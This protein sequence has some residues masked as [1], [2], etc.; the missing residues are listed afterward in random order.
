MRKTICLGLA[1]LIG[2]AYL[3]VTPIA[4]A[5]TGA[6]VV[7]G[8][9]TV[10]STWKLKVSPDKDALNRPLIATAFEV[11]Q[12]IVGQRWS[13]VIRRDTTT[14][15]SSNNVITQAPSG[16]F[17]VVSRFSNPPGQNIITAIASNAATGERCQARIV[18]TF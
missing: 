10:R 4:S 8:V 7:T 3:G 1:G 18:A 9:C 13:V 16:D 2:A 11:D 14:V 17:K 6:T 5:K 15:F 12:N